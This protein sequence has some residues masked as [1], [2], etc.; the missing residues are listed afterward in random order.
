VTDLG[1]PG[2]KLVERARDAIKKYSMVSPGDSVLVALSGGPDSTCLLDVLARLTS[3]LDMSLEVAHVDHGLSDESEDIAAAVT[4]RAA[5][6]G[7]EVHFVAAPDL[8][9]PNLQARARDF[10]YAFLE[11]VAKN[12]GFERVA[13]GHTLDDRAETTVARLIHGAGTRGLAGLL[14]VDGRRIRPLISV[15]RAE[16]RAYCEERGLEFIDD[17]ANEDD[18]FERVAVRK[19]IIAAVE[20]RWGPGAV[21]AI[22]TS[23]ERLGEDAQAIEGLAA[24][25]FEQI[26]AREDSRVAFK[27]DAFLLT[28]KAFRRRLLETAMGRVRDRSGGIDEALEALDRDGSFVGRFSATGGAEIVVTDDSVSV[29]GVPEKSSEAGTTLDR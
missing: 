5:Q 20:E 24:A 25:V 8:E 7:Y 2:Y 23:A 1:G 13:T 21:G 28:P 19:R 10:R 29:V 27:K 14:P 4:S 22:A 17:P 6:A 11:T 12:A 16:T 3:T 26:A 9:G 15:R 18:H